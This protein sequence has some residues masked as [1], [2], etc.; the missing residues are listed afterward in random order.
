MNP[1]GY[2]TEKEIEASK[3]KSVD[4]VNG[5]VNGIHGTNGSH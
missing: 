5:T 3:A 1:K 2:R 4:S